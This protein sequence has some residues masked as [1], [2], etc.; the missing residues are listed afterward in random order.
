MHQLSLIRVFAV[1]MGKARV[2]AD[3]ILCSAHIYFV[4]VLSLLIIPT[5]SLEKIGTLISFQSQSLIRL[6]VR[7]SVTILVNVS[8]SE[9]FDVA[10]S[11]FADV[12]V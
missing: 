9:P 11:N 3:Q 7:W 5:Y 8:L 10:T 2:K 1:S 6:P 4:S 12:H